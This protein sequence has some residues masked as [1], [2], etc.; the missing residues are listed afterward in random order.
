LSEGKWIILV[1]E[2]ACRGGVLSDDSIR[3]SR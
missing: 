1:K 3:A 2:T